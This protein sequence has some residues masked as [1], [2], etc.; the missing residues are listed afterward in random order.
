MTALELWL[1]GLEVVQEVANEELTCQYNGQTIDIGRELYTSLKSVFDGVQ[2]NVD[3]GILEGKAFQGIDSPVVVRVKHNGTPLKNLGL[4]YEFI[5]GEGQIT[6]NIPT[7]EKGET[8]FYVRNVTSKL[9][10]QEIAVTLDPSFLG[11][12]NKVYIK[13]F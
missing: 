12:L 7:D 1:Q 2:I 6:G 10:E 8:S 3:P 4:K 5:T 11:G 13:S 9:A